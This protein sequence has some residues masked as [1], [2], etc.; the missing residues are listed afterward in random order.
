MSK[1]SK[2]NNKE[3]QQWYS[4]YNANYIEKSVWNQITLDKKLKTINSLNIVSLVHTAVCT[5]AL[6]SFRMNCGK[7]SL[8]LLKQ[9]ADQQE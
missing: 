7:K 1:V 5:N 3:Y 6:I 8:K 4:W 2:R 9:L